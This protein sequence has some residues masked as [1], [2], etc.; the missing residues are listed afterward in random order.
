MFGFSLSCVSFSHDEH[1]ESQGV[2]TY[3]VNTDGG[4]VR[5]SVGIIGKSKQQARLAYTGVT[6]EK[7]LEEI[8]VSEQVGV[9]VG[10]VVAFIL[11]VRVA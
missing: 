3:K 5:F 2:G 1:S 8:V 7:Q 10:A 11:Q 9:L 4:D 6:D